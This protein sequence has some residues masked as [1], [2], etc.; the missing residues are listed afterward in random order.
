MADNLVYR[1]EV[2][3]GGLRG[4]KPDEFERLL[5]ESAEQGWSL[6][7]FSH[8]PNTNRMW[9]VLSSPSKGEGRSSGRKADWSLNWG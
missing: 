9:V 2:L 8:Q 6:H 4:A 7:S 1:V 3:G 5:N